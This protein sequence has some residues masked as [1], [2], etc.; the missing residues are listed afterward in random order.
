MTEAATDPSQAAHGPGL[1]DRLTARLLQ[2]RWLM[3]M[4]IPLYRAG[5]GWIFGERLV[6][7]E[8]VGRVSGEPR[9][10]VVEVVERAPNVLRV[11]S[12]FGT[13]SQWYRNLRAHGVAYLSTGRA[14]RVRAAVRL[15][16]RTE[17]DAVLERYAVAHP[18]AWKHLS[19]AVEYAAGGDAFVPVVEFTP[20]EPAARPASGAVPDTA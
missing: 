14:R 2:T 9:F 4:P 20:P 15:L 12:G 18:D 16:D 3:R 6:M 10:V 11:A 7:I 8:H 19:S 17:S 1:A 13:R 5:L